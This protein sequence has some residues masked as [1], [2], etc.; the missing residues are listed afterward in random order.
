MAAAGRLAIDAVLEIESYAQSR[1]MTDFAFGADN[2][3]RILVSLY[4]DS[5]KG[6]R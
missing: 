5:R 6:G 3:Q 2:I 4:I 1:G